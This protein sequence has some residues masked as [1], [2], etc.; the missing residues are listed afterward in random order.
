LEHLWMSPS[1]LSVVSTHVFELVETSPTHVQRLCV[2]AS[3]SDSGIRFSFT[4]VP[5]IC[6]V[7]SVE[8]LY[9]KFGF[10]RG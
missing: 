5:G 7:S 6:K 9:K 10:P 3:I 1:V 8:E 2:P 4:L